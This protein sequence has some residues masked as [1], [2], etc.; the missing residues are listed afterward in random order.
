MLDAGL[1]VTKDVIYFGMIGYKDEVSKLHIFA[2]GS[3]LDN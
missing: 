2:V 1:C 3:D